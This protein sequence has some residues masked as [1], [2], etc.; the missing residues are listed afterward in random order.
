MEQLWQQIQIIKC[1]FHFELTLEL[2]FHVLTETFLFQELMSVT[3]VIIW[4]EQVGYF[5]ATSER[6]VILSNRLWLDIGKD[7]CQEDIHI[8]NW[9]L[10]VEKGNVSNTL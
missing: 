10:Q 7:F 1:S 3:R 2:V 8:L 5:P 4:A 6:C 9:H